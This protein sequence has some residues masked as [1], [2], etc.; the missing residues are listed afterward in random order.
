MPRTLPGGFRSRSLEVFVA[1]LDVTQS[2]EGRTLQV[3]SP[4]R[5]QLHRSRQSNEGSPYRL[6][7]EPSG[8]ALC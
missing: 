8:E 7:P 4:R 2:H 6:C 1:L 5:V 3:L